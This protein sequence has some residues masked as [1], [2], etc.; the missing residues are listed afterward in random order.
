[1]SKRIVKMGVLGLL[2]LG[3]TVVF[4]ETY[5][6]CI[7]GCGTRRLVTEMGC[8]RDYSSQSQEYRICM[9]GAAT[10]FDIEKRACDIKYGVE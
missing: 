6:T 5:A 1:M 10:T 8:A 2:L 9:A 7:A 3:A 4:A